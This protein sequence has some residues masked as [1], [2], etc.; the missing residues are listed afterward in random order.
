MQS[1]WRQRANLETPPTL[2][3][4]SGPCVF[5]SKVDGPLADCILRV[6]RL[7]EAPRAIPILHPSIMR[8]ICYWL[9]TSRAW[10]KLCRL[11]LPET[12]ASR[13]SRAIHLIRTDLATQY[14]DWYSIRGRRGRSLLRAALRF[15]GCPAN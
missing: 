10:W 9:L 6:I 1:A 15:K 5:V 12:N 11:V 4:D 13:V 7:N 3:S 14:V 8:E 2:P